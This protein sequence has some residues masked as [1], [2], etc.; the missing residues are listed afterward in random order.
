MRK[1]TD[2]QIQYIAENF[3]KDEKFAGWMNIAKPL[4]TTGSCVVAGNECIWIGGIGN[5]IKVS[6]A[7]NFIDCVTYE[8]DLE[9]FL[10][11]LWFKNVH[12]NYLFKLF[13][14]KKEIEQ[15]IEE[16]GK[17]NDFR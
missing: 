12:K 15:K 1:L 3:F 14:E 11:S 8:F 5:F 7:D 2:N 13:D 4:L 10:S 6:K 16:L 9:S 17:L